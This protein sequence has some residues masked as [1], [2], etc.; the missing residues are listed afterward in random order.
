MTP[1]LSGTTRSVLATLVSVLVLFPAAP[2]Q[3]DEVPPPAEKLIVS[4]VVVSGT[5][6]GAGTSF[7]DVRPDNTG[8]TVHY[9]DFRVF[10]NGGSTPLD[11]RKSCQLSL[12]LQLPQ[13][14]TYA[15]AGVGSRG[16]ADIARGAQGVQRSTFYYAGSP[17]VPST[18][19]NFSGP[20]SDYW[21]TVDE[22]PLGQLVW[23]PCNMRRL[24]NAST[25]L[26]VVKG[27]SDPNVTPTFLTQESTEY[28]IA[29]RRC[30]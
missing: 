2:A 3:A 17:S 4:A 13:G 7:I 26:R 11:A 19:H 23:V 21:E 28:S 16:D 18:T 29:W 15:I 12:S 1:N 14:F 8:F 30:P 9:A 24:L 22:I 5:G 25:E 6:C 27:T 20:Y 10:L